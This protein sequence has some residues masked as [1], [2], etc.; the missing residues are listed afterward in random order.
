MN[1]AEA[2]SVLEAHCADPH[3]GLPEEVFLLLTRL[4]PMVNVDLL[5]NDDHTGQTLLTWRNDIYHGEGWHI[6]GGVIRLKETA[7]QRIAAVARLELKCR[8][9]AEDRPAAINEC[10]SKTKANRG[11]A[12]SLLYRCKLTSSLPDELRYA[13]GR[14]VPGMYHYFD[15][16]PE[17]LLKVHDIY[18][19]FIGPQPR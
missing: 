13:G 7:D 19:E 15:R 12:V 3:S 5:I 8:V 18:R 2:I 9:V 17:N 10:I 4:T 14:P 16:A 1:L 11:H 6:P